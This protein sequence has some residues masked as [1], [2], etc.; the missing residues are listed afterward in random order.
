[1]NLAAVLKLDLTKQAILV[2]VPEK[3]VH[4]DREDKP[5]YKVQLV[6][7]VV[8]GCSMDTALDTFETNVVYVRQD[9]L[10]SDG[11]TFV[12]ENDHSKGFYR[13]G[14]LVDFSQGQA[15][16]LYQDMTIKAW[17]RGERTNRRTTRRDDL[18][19]K[20][21]SGLLGK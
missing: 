13:D 20:I 9:D 12:D 8:V 11:W 1:M 21:Q 15:L 18:N 3:T 19:K 4:M 6:E 2:G 7:P 17:S 14:W 10:N 5:Y 16:P